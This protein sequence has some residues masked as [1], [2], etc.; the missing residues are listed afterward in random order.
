MID[1]AAVAAD[2]DTR[3]GNLPD[4]AG[5]LRKLRAEY[6]RRLAPA[7]AGVIFALAEELLPS[8]HSGRFIAYELIQHHRP[9]LAGLRARHLTRLARGMDNWAAVDAFACYLAGPAWRERQVPDTLVRRWADSPDR[10]WRRAALVCTVALNCPA[11]G[12]RGDTAR[13]LMI[14]RLLVADR[15]DMVVKA[16]SWALRELAKRDA[17]AVRRFLVEHQDALAPRVRREVGNKIRTGLK[18]P[19]GRTRR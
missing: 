7:P 18:N 8:S 10:W 15:D 2:I 4:R 3:L 12:G 19:R 13:T 11:R 9:A 6:S 16:M 5:P 17:S 1:P 14:C